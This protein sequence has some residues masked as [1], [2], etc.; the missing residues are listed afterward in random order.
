VATYLDIFGGKV[1]YL[2]SDPTY[3][4]A[5]QVWY[6]STA[7]TAKV[8]LYYNGV[9]STSSA[10]MN[11]GRKTSGYAGSSGSDGMMAGGITLTPP[12]A[13]ANQN[14]TET[15]NGTTWTT[16][17]NI[18]STRRGLGT[19]GTSSTSALIFGGYLD[20]YTTASESWDGTNWTG[21]P[22]LNTA[23]DNIGGAGT[24]TSALAVAGQQS[25]S[26]TTQVES[27][28][29]SSWTVGT[30]TPGVEHLWIGTAGK[31]NSDVLA[32]GG[33]TYSGGYTSYQTC[34]LWDGSSWT[35]KNPTTVASRSNSGK[36]CTSTNAILNF[37]GSPDTTT[38]IWDG[39]SWTA[40]NAL[41]VGQAQAGSNGSGA[42][43]TAAWYAG[44]GAPSI[45]S[46]GDEGWTGTQVYQFG[47]ATITLGA[48]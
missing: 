3:K 12:G 2:T 33:M 11:N 9:W 47:P 22:S 16:K 7:G 48:S 32:W 46:P 19:A 31:S 44:G 39:T 34:Y 35:T 17:N 13:Q 38:E 4:N 8:E 6:N 29:G 43:S 21:T 40:G 1:K 14:A 5:G 36:A 42:S 10:T 30:S 27:Y 28:N 45:T 20:P 37:G 23:R 15:F 24:A 41:P 18:G 26:V 25:I